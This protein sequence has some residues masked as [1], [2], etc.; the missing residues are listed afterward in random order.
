MIDIL[1]MLL[2]IPPVIIAVM[3][4]WTSCSEKGADFPTND[5]IG[6]VALALFGISLVGSLRSLINGNPSVFAII[7][8]ALCLVVAGVCFYIYRRKKR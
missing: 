2:G 8:C 5:L 6:G 1:I 3:W 4:I 7:A